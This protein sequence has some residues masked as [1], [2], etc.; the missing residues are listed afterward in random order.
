MTVVFA[1]AV[2]E[3]GALAAAQERFLSIAHGFR[4]WL[5]QIGTGTW[6][7]V[8]ALVVLVFWKKRR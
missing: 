4:D 8:I 1:Q 6:V 5:S 2:G 3:Y 7:V